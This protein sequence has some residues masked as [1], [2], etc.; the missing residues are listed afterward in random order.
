MPDAR[1]FPLDEVLTIT[2]SKLV[3]RRRMDAVYDALN[4]LTGDNL[5][6]RR[7]RPRLALGRSD[8]GQVRQDP[9]ARPSR[10]V[11]APGPDRG[12]LRPHGRRE[13]LRRPGGVKRVTLP[14]SNISINPHDKGRFRL[15]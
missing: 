4:Y 15:V 2:T 1:E 6:T 9:V 14:D 3:A 10:P 8:G 7:R 12:S 11:G 5:F 13:G